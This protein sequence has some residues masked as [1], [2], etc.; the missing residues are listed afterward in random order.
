[1]RN[2]IDLFTFLGP[3]SAEYAEYLKYTAELFSSGNNDINWKCINSIGCDRM[4]EGYDV[5]DNGPNM[6]QVSM[7][8]GVSLNLAMKYIESKYVIFTD[9][10]IAIL[11]KNWDEVIINELNEYDCFGGAFSNSLRRYRNFPSVY[12]FTFRSDILDKVKLDFRPELRKKKINHKK[13]HVNNHVLNEQESIY[14]NMKPGKTVH[15]DTG[16]RLP[17]IIREAGLSYNT[18]PA[19]SIVSKKICLKFE[20]EEQEEICKRKPKHMSEWHYHGKL[21]ATHKHSSYGTPLDSEVGN[22][23]KDRIKLYIKNYKEEIL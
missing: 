21:F 9:V 12:F 18:M 20:N 17:F 6:S 16:W 5:V 1:M 14:Y 10:D 23:W 15:C 13:I 2:K 4:P 22:A 3:N 8:H 19:V 11:Y 7:N